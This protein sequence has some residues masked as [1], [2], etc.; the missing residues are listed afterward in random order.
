MRAGSQ[1]AKGLAAFR[2]VLG[3]DLAA[4]KNHLVGL[5]SKLR[6]GDPRQLVPQALASNMQR[7]RHGT[8]EVAELRAIDEDVRFMLPKQIRTE[9]AAAGAG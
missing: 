8:D 9:L 1:P 5:A 4:G 2:R 6:G 7:A 3:I